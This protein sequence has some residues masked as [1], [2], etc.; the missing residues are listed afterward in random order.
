MDERVLQ[1]RVGVMV[2][3]TVF[4]AVIL[5]M[6]FNYSPWLLRGRYTVYVKLAEAPGVQRDTPVRKSGVLIGR[7]SDVHLRERDVLLTLRIDS[8]YTVHENETCRVGTETLLGDAMME[9]VAE[10]PADLGDPI[11]DGALLE[12]KVKGDALQALEV[13]VELQDDINLASAEIQQAAHR[14]GELSGNLNAM[15]VNN[16]QQIGRVVQKSEL[17]MDEFHTAMIG[18]NEL[19]GDPQMRADLKAS[20]AG[21]PD[22][23]DETRV[24]VQKYGAVAERADRSLAEAEKFA[25]TLG[26]LGESSQQMSGNI[27]RITQKLDRL[28][29]DLLAVSDAINKQEGTIGQLVY[30]PELYQRLNRAANNVEQVSR[31]LR[32]IVEDVRVFSDKIARDPSQLGVRGA[33]RRGDSGN[34]FLPMSFFRQDEEPQPAYPYHWAPYGTAPHYEAPPTVVPEYE[35]YVR[36]QPEYAVP[37]LSAP[38]FNAPEVIAPQ[39]EAPP[40]AGTTTPQAFWQSQ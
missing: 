40:T 11:T 15:V 36:P 5:V 29:I 35:N 38:E 22:L 17:A 37:Q 25:Q 31:R 24:A 19:V 18:V 21:V 7:V 20:M 1:F 28:I 13:L 33:L 34:K 4:I 23:L 3:G 26:K 39:Y 16:Q 6:I 12:G 27:D 2:V 10:K 14:V 9:F 32:P 8:K 30:N